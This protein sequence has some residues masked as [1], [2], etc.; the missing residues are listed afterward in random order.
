MAQKSELQ[1]HVD[2]GAMLFDIVDGDEKDGEVIGQIRFNPSDID[3]ARRCEKVM[4][5]FNNLTLGENATDEELF[6]ATDEIKKQF[7]YLLNYENSEEIFKKANPMTPTTN[8]DFYCEQVLN[9]IVGLIEKI[10]DQR[11]EKKKAK[12]KKATAKYHK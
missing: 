2:T 4:E 12:I 3:I 11:I 9:A 5:F 10:T 1:L 8:G 6:A 7:D